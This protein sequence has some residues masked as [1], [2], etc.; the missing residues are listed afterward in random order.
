MTL[1]AKGWHEH[2]QH[3]QLVRSRG[4]RCRGLDLQAGLEAYALQRTKSHRPSS[5]AIAHYIGGCHGTCT[6]AA[7]IMPSDTLMACSCFIL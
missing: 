3:I 4:L 7:N 2:R 1:A 6:T 5:L